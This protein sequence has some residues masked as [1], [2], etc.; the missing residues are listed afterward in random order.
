M[1]F[2]VYT[3]KGR[4]YIALEKYHININY[5]W[6]LY[7]KGLNYILA[8]LELVKGSIKHTHTET[9]TQSMCVGLCVFNVRPLWSSAEI[10]PSLSIDILASNI[11]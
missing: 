1:Q 10:V 8:C 4:L 9:D 5:V 6:D 7:V 3:S 11:P 2:I